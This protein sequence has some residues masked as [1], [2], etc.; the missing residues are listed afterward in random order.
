MRYYNNDF[1]D[2]AAAAVKRGAEALRSKT[3]EEKIEFLVNAGILG[4]NGKLLPQFLASK[5][6]KKTGKKKK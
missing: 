6:D 4:V 3:R 1:A 2:E 5:E